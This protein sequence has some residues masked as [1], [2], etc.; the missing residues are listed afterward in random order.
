MISPACCLKLSVLAYELLPIQ[1]RTARTKRN[2]GPYGYGRYC[3][4][5]KDPHGGMVIVWFSHIDLTTKVTTVVVGKEICEAPVM[6]PAI[7]SAAS[8]APGPWDGLVALK[9]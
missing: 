6:T 7:P 2:P 3:A 1:Y 5:T 4:Q 8:V 9:S